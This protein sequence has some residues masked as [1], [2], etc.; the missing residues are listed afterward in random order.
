MF[1]LLPFVVLKK[2]KK[3]CFNEQRQKKIVPF[4][5]PTWVLSNTPSERFYHTHTKPTCLQLFVKETKEVNLHIY[6]LFKYIDVKYYISIWSFDTNQ[7]RLL[8]FLMVKMCIYSNG[9]INIIITSI[10]QPLPS[11]SCL[12]LTVELQWQKPTGVRVLY[13]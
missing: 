1:F 9:H 7:S 2:R 4:L 8:L 11:H 6:I 13:L 5:K 12:L 3:A 10:S